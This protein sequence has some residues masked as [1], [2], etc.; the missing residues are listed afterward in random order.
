ML[1]VLGDV[2]FFEKLL[3]SSLSAWMNNF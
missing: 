3:F 2:H 1:N